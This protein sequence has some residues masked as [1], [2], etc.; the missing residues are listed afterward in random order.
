MF[1]NWG[2]FFFKDKYLVLIK[3]ECKL[4]ILLN[5]VC[6]VDLFDCWNDLSKN[7]NVFGILNE[8]YFN[9]LII[10]GLIFLIKWWSFLVINLFMNW[11]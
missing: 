7:R 6:F 1:E 8:V 4:I 9:S 3:F 5:F 11:L 10:F 2:I